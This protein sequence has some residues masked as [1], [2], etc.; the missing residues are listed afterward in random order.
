MMDSQLS[1]IPVRELHLLYALA[2]M[3]EQY[4]SEQ[5]EGRSVL[6][7]MCISAGE[8]AYK[9]LLAYDLIHVGGRGATWTELGL[10]L[11]DLRL[12]QQPFPS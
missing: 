2:L 12:N 3:C 10:E 7:H 1:Q 8:E 6:D 9:A 11:L 4:M 5:H